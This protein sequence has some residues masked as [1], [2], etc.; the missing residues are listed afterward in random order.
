MNEFLS[1]GYVEEGHV[2]LIWDL[3][4]STKEVKPKL[5]PQVAL[6]VSPVQKGKGCEQSMKPVTGWCAQ[7]NS[8]GPVIHVDVM[9][10]ELF[11]TQGFIS[12]CLILTRIYDQSKQINK[13]HFPQPDSW[14]NSLRCDT[15]EEILC[16]KN[17]NWGVQGKNIHHQ[18]GGPAGWHVS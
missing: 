16:D 6:M 15:K 17:A 12:G 9:G 10:V 13:W 5:K 18:K 1:S 7:K 14:W 11:F 2:C 8:S 4:V 3:E